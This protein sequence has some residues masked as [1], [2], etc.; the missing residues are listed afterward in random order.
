MPETTPTGTAPDV[1]IGLLGYAFMGKAHSNAYKKIPYMMY[2][3]PAIPRLAAICGLEADE[4]AKAANRY[5][6]TASYTDYEAMLKDPDVQVLDN[7]G[8]NYIH[9]PAS[10]AAAQAGKH[11]FCEKPLGLNAGEA[12]AMLDA[13]LKAGVKHMVGFNYRFA[14]AV[15]LAYELIQSGR[16]GRLYHFRARYL[17]DWLIP[18]SQTKWH[19]RVNKA[20]T[21]SGALGDLGAHI[22][23]LS[24]FLLGAEIES[25]C[26]MTRT[27]IS[28]RPKEDGSG[29]GRVDV[30]DAFAAAA[31][32]SN[33]VLGTLEASRF[34]TGHKNDNTFEINAENGSLRF[35]LE[36]INELEVMWVDAEAADE[37]TRQTQ[38]FRQVLV[39]DKDHP[40][41]SNWWPAGHVIGWEHTFVHELTHFL[42]CV[43]NDH[44]VAPYG[45]TFEDGLRVAE[46]CDAIA[47]SAQSRRQI[48][49]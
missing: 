30:D 26:A 29:M 15:R 22:I 28:E 49:L 21:G 46:V 42:G 47:A 40:Y 32:Y 23:D 35:S 27:F 20:E 34:A 17:Q 44:P 37:T 2:P 6:Y 36:R 1:G 3:P 11:V 7:S 9:A 19:W 31:S 12:Q 14:P 38:G 33:G 41:I 39:T 48:D 16:L 24:R 13:V 18:A 10:I 45:A 4:A 5:G 25:V 43:V 8:P